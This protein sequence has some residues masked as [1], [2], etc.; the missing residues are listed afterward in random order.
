M[1]YNTSRE[2]YFDIPSQ[3]LLVNDTNH[4]HI[5]VDSLLRLSLCR[6]TQC[7]FAFRLTFPSN[8]PES[9][10]K[11]LGNDHVVHGP[12]SNS[13]ILLPATRRHDKGLI[14]AGWQSSLLRVW[15]VA[16]ARN[17]EVP[18]AT[19][20]C[21][22]VTP[23]S[24][25]IDS[26]GSRLFMIIEPVGD[27]PNFETNVLIVLNIT[28][29]LLL[30]RLSVGFDFSLRN[31]EYDET[32]DL[33]IALEFNRTLVNGVHPPSQSSLVLLNHET[34]HREHVAYLPELPRTG[35][36]AYNRRDGIYYYI[37][38][39]TKDIQ[40]FSL[41]VEHEQ[42]GMDGMVDTVKTYKTSKHLSPIRIGG[43][44]DGKGIVHAMLHLETNGLLYTL[45]GPWPPKDDDGIVLCRY[46]AEDPKIVGCATTSITGRDISFAVVSIQP[47]NRMIVMVQSHGGFATYYL[48][49]N[50]TH[51]EQVQSIGLHGTIVHLSRFRDRTPIITALSTPSVL[52]NSS[53]RVTL[54]GFNF[55]MRDF[56]PIV[57]FQPP[58]FWPCRGE[59]DC[60][61]QLL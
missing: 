23:G 48:E 6:S 43:G 58:V 31:L 42:V 61:S 53:D 40:R 27:S 12:V 17:G 51:R 14:V 50:R 49:S 4:V 16:R 60:L 59:C 37:L 11:H 44:V 22:P 19:V 39:S 35:I 52:L 45:E 34:G 25:T 55:G 21:N 29:G 7:E 36:T 57:G 33:I 41:Q 18:I 3:Y 28:N 20:E 38:Q 47:D 54:T 24:L 10:K 32:Y 1:P 46:N 30:R 8:P 9:L 2:K 13:L 5:T 15:D 26:T 56:A